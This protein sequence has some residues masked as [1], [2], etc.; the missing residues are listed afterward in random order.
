MHPILFYMFVERNITWLQ[1]SPFVDSDL[2]VKPCDESFLLIRKC[3]DYRLGQD[4]LEKTKM[5]TNTQKREARIKSK[6]EKIPRK[7][8]YL[9]KNV[10]NRSQHCTKHQPR[11]GR[12]DL[13]TFLGHLVSNSSRHEGLSEPYIN[14]KK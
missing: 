14:S 12:I 5:N 13:Q 7:K 1:R 9:S 6:H 8:C 10:S 4:M 2:C 11:P 3:V